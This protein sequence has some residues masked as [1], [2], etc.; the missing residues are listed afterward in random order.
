MKAVVCR[1]RLNDVRY[2][3]AK[4]NQKNVRHAV[5]VYRKKAAEVHR[6]HTIYPLIMFTV[7]YP[8]KEEM[9]TN[10]RMCSEH[11]SNLV[12]LSWSLLG[13]EI[14]GTAS[15]K[16]ITLSSTMLG[17]IT[18]PPLKWGKPLTSQSKKSHQFY[19]FH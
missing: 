6:T 8:F 7:M 14:K 18:V 16:G 12:K 11:I 1:C 10:Q 17:L 5:S 3:I 19:D 2:L 13:T 4:K 9:D 15:L